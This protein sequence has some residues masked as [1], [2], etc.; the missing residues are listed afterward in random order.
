MM[1][2]SLNGD[3]TAYRR[4]LVRLSGHLRA[5]FNG[6]LS[7]VGRNKAEAEDLVQETLLAI[8]ISRHTYDPVEPFTPWLHA[9]ARYKLIDHLRRTLSTEAYAPVDDAD[10]LLTDTDDNLDAES[11]LDLN[12]LLVHLPEKMRQSIQY[13]KIDGFSVAEAARRFEISESDVKISIH[14][15]LKTLAKIIAG[16]KRS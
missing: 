14:R 15:G 1:L 2:A 4:L 16:G 9:V 13:V 6:R 11:A 3:S 8:H 7:R 5:Y 10:E 12:R